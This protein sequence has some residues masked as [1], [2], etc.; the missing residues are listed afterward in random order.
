MISFLC[1]LC[2][3]KNNSKWSSSSSII[4]VGTY[5]LAEYRSASRRR[6]LSFEL[7]PFLWSTFDA[8]GWFD[9]G[10]TSRG[11][12]CA[13]EVDLG[14]YLRRRS[15]RGNPCD[16]LDRS[17]SCLDKIITL[18]IGKTVHTF[19]ECSVQ[20]H[21]YVSSPWNVHALVSKDQSKCVH[22]PG[23]NRYP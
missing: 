20:H 4:R 9:G 10:G 12:D 23:M 7:L 21:E 1:L 5:L 22:V 15:R 11:V 2:P 13:K 18:H 19:S 6:L 14:A 16:S 8:L 3:W 17:S